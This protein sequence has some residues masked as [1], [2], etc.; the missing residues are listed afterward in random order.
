VLGGV[1]VRSRSHG[2]QRKFFY[3][4]HV[5]RFRGPE[6]C[7]QHLTLPIED[8]DQAVLQAIEQHVLNSRVVAKALEYAIQEI[9][10]S[11][12]DPAD[13]KEQLLK[14]LRATETELARFTAAIANG[15]SLPTIVSA[16]QERESR[17]ATLQTQLAMLDGTQADRFDP[18][19]AEQE[20]RQYLDD[21]T[22]LARRHPAQTRQILRKL[23][24][25]RIRLSR[26]V[27]G[28]CHFEGEAAIG[29]VING[30]AGMHRA[31]GRGNQLGVPN[32]I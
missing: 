17:K 27:D 16:M 3:C 4:C 10:E 18:K 20:I 29:K 1:F 32:G 28:R 6:A 23:L 14:E 30:L 21:W 19:Q 15:G 31:H 8:V 7:P 2:S 5:H 11:Q 12:Q 9:R 13:R 25:K 24:V 26:G 22:G